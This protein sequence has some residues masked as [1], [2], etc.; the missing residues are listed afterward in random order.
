MSKT[1]GDRTASRTAYAGWA[2][3]AARLLFLALVVIMPLEA[4]T[5]AREMALVGAAL[6]MALHLWLDPHRR[7][8]PTAL[9]LPLALYVAAALLSLVWAVDFSYSLRELRGEVLKGILVYYTAAH[10][11][12]HR[13]HLA[14]V[15]G[16]L[17][18][19][20]AIMVL[21]G[22]GLFYY[23]GG[24]IFS[25]RVRAGSL[26]NGY[27]GL[28]TYLVTVWPY[29]LLAPRAFPQRR[30]RPWLWGLIVLTAFMAYL[31]YN[32]A[33]W[34]GMVVGMGMCLL[35][36][37]RHR[38]RSAL[39]GALLV[40]ALA[41]GMFLLPG[42]THGERW[43]RLWHDPQAVGGTAG[44]LAALWSYSLERIAERPFRGIGLGRHSFSKA[45]PDFR[46]THQPLLWHA[47]NMFV[48]LALQL[49]LQGLA[50]MVLV[51][52]VLVAKL[53]PRAPPDPGRMPQLFCGATAVMVVG[54]AVRNLTDDFFADDSALLFWLLAGLGMGVQW[55]HSRA[56]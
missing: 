44:D 22:V 15:Y 32:R 30:L 6:F 41:G 35:M 29:V 39:L 40:L 36:L 43:S 55:W 52:A 23:Y 34:L 45:F 20:V 38:L 47:H 50:A 27:G 18:A 51:M 54:F 56:K 11:V 26:H 8:R 17:L 14:Q 48:D 46:R 42:A 7:L 33:A 3:R 9:A 1:P 53:W 10:L 2:F 49:G 28:G 24:S 31:T 19:G 25:M 16:V 5:A 4:V 37:S 21:A 12:S 13:D